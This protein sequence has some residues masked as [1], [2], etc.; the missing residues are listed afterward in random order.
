VVAPSGQQRHRT[1]TVATPVLVSLVL[2]SALGLLMAERSESTD[3]MIEL[4]GR[5]EAGEA[6]KPLAT[7]TTA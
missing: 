3:V 6:S 1:V 2:F 4:I 7:P 5:D